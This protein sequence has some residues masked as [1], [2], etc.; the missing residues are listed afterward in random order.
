MDQIFQH[1]FRFH[2]HTF[3]ER[4]LAHITINNPFVTECTEVGITGIKGFQ[5]VIR[6]CAVVTIHNTPV[7]G[8]LRLAVYCFKIQCNTTGTGIVLQEVIGSRITEQFGQEALTAYC[9]P[10]SSIIG[11]RN[12]AAPR[13]RPAMPPISK[14]PTP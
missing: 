10:V 8:T 13:A 14:P 5:S 4:L 7:I 6:E 1:Y 3:I 2:R 12:A 9:I 11:L